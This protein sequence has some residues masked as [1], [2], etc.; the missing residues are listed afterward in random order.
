MLV[1]RSY[2]LTVAF[3]CVAAL[4]CA[5]AAA[6]TRAAEPSLLK[7]ENLRCE[8]RVDPLGIDVPRPRLSWNLTS[9]RR[10]QRQTAYQVL[11]ASSAGP[12]ARGAGDLWDS[13]KVASDR[14]VHVAYAGTPLASA[15]QCFWSLRVWDGDDRPS[16][17]SPPASWTMGL[18]SQDDW[19]AKWIT[20]DGAVP[21]DKAGH[22]STLLRRE[23]RAKPGLRRALVFVCGLGQYEL[24]VNGRKSGNDLL[25]PG[26]TG[27]RKT[28]LYDT[29]DVTAMLREGENALGLIL[30]NGM[31]NV[32]GGRYAKYTGSMGPQK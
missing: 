26:W 12:L 21:A 7:A 10:A 18:L 19:Q 2:V 15:Q 30:G 8:F 1:Q 22:T 9:P 28:C 31:Y 5:A 16:A 25:A 27:Y 13:G 11:V 6:P 17:W 32:V 14:A 4:L 20:A 24:T 29:H 3:I 23:L